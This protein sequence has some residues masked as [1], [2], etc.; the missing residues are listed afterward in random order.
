[1][2][3]TFPELFTS[4]L[5]LRKIVASDKQVVFEGLSS[6]DVIKY[7]GVSYTSFE[8]TA[9]QMKFYNDL[10]K[11]ETGIWWAICFKDNPA[12]MIGACGFNYR[13]HQKKKI[14]IG[15]WLL[16]GYFGKGIMAEAVPVITK[17]AFAEMDIHRVEAVVED[18]N[19]KSIK[20]LKKL[21]FNYEGTLVD[22]EIKNG[23]LSVCNTGL[24]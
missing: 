20:L 14:E 1:M 7:Y 2:F 12:E 9:N 11:D 4:R 19:D 10:L 16:L 3:T 6:P 22:S 21:N 5:L 17:Y 15:Y 13:N 8:A 24:Y 23:A 18:E